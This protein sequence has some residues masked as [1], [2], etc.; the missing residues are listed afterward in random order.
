M[1]PIYFM[2]Q[3]VV[4]GAA[5]LPASPPPS[6]RLLYWVLT[7]HVLRASDTGT[8]IDGLLRVITFL[9]GYKFY[10]S[11]SPGGTTTPRSPFGDIDTGLVHGRIA[12]KKEESHK[13]AQ[14]RLSSQEIESRDIGRI[15][16]GLPRVGNSTRLDTTLCIFSRTKVHLRQD[17]S[18]TLLICLKIK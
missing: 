6:F 1:S 17:G 11:L 4:L 2:S 16:S 18:K 7:R 15:S 9:Q 5:S 3:S 8:R 13:A 12:W 10:S 14:S